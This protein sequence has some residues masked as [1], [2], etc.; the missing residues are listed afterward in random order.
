MT[1]EA[2][3]G[4]SLRDR[5]IILQGLDDWINR[6]NEEQSKPSDRNERKGG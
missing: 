2:W 6:L 3:L 1:V 4:L 5:K